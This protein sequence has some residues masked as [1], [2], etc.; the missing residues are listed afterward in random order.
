MNI[1]LAALLAIAVLAGPF[2]ATQAGDASDDLARQVAEVERAFAA[3]M[4]DR[5]HDAFVGFLSEET[6][7]FNGASALRGREAVAALWK[8][9]FIEAEAPFSWEPETV[10]VLDSGTLAL[11]S[12]PVR[13]PTG[14]RV[15]T[16]NSIWRLESSGQWRIIFDKGSR[17]CPGPSAP[18]GS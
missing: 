10:E 5:D 14:Q 13:N 11:S 7:F 1:R 12:G 17:D 2:S 6:V 18:E 15:A 4:S 16:F 3:T 9:Y 8:E